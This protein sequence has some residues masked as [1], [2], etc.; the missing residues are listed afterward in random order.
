MSSV[1][2]SCHFEATLCKSL[3][4]YLSAIISIDMKYIQPVV[5]FFA[6]ILF[7]ISVMAFIKHKQQEPYLLQ[8]EKEIAVKEKGPHNGG[9]ETTAYPFFAKADDFTIVFRK[10]TLQPGSSI[11]YHLQEK[12]EVYYILSGEGEMTINGKSFPVTA[13]DAIL[14][15]PGNSHGLKPAKDHELSLII[16]YEK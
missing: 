5:M 12:N 16:N 15:R 4:H 6:G 10:R 13:G 14:T 1:Q 8:H 9:G 7:S 2:L 11:G 3:M